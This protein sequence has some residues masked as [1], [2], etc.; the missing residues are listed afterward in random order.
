MIPIL[1]ISTKWVGCN[2]AQNYAQNDK[3]GM[4]T[5]VYST[6][7]AN[8]SLVKETVAIYVPTFVQYI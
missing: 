1:M 8:W 5:V 7:N 4:S 2:C 6:S 3:N